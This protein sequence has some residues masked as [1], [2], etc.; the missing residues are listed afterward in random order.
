VEN[1]EA[2]NG[3]INRRRRFLLCTMMLPHPMHVCG[4]C[5]FVAYLSAVLSLAVLCFGFYIHHTV[6][7]TA[8]CLLNLLSPHATIH[9]PPTHS[10]LLHEHPDNT[11][12]EA[13][14]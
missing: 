9:Q 4:V 13:T 12:A 11:H 10:V 1:K 8:H 6:Q 5:L 14:E 7:F 2:G 3:H